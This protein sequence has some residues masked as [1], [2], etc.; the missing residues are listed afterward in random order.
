MH[1]VSFTKMHLKISSAIWRPFC[2]GGDELNMHAV[3]LR[4]VFVWLFEQF[5]T[6]PQDISTHILQD[7][8]TGTASASAVTLKDMG[9]ITAPNHK[10][11]NTAK[12]NDSDNSWDVLCMFSTSLKLTMSMMTS[13][14]GN[15]FRVTGLLCGEFTGPGEFPSQRPVT[16]SFDVFSDLR[17][18]KRL[19]KQSQGWWFQTQSRSLWR[20]CNALLFCTW[21]GLHFGNFPNVYHSNISIW[22]LLTDANFVPHDGDTS[23]RFAFFVVSRRSSET[24]TLI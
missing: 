3:L 12:R 20:Y 1:N 13:S 24:N 17:L 23:L 19:S 8:F 22:L 15:I 7:Y 14:N 21:C 4:F 6:A 9:K 16:R 2:P 11:I 10:T 5:V 18:N